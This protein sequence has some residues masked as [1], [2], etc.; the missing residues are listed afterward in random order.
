M[1]KFSLFGWLFIILNL[2]FF[3]SSVSAHTAHEHEEEEKSEKGPHGGRLL[4]DGHFSL[5][6]TIFE[7]GV[8]PEFRLF[9][10]NDN[11]PIHPSEVTAHITLYRLGSPPE[12]ITFTPIDSFLKSNQIIHEPHSF[13]VTVDA[14][15]QEK[16]HQWQFSTYEG[17]TQ[18]A[19]ETADATGI[20]TETAGPQTI[21]EEVH[22]NGFI[23]LNPNTT[24]QVRARFPGIVKEVKKNIGEEVHV[25]D[26]LA[27]VESNESLQPYPITAPLNGTILRRDTNIGD[28][29]R[30]ASLFTIASLD[31]VW[32]ELYV[33]PQDYNKIK[34]GQPLLIHTSTSDDTTD[35]IIS[36]V[37]PV[38]DLSSQTYTIRA[39]LENA[40]RKWLPGMALQGTAIIEKHAVPL[41]V[42]N[43]AIQRFRDFNVV[44]Q[45]VGDFY[46]VRMLELGKKDHTWTEVLSGLSPGASYV[47]ENSFLIKADIE[48]SGAVHDH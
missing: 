28:V 36:F 1:N 21:L 20:E 40:N 10:Y 18:I 29:A 15:Y 45:Q 4:R 19:K 9:P 5:E 26:V 39:V 3:D 12:E 24:A 42:K 31:N 6:L 33:F 14:Q 13:D 38:A 23:V 46:E 7:K 37:T 34:V 22:L 17:R 8:P 2:L 41:A 16:S 48:K 35:S 44:F 27:V 32:A 25:G 30:D 11:K 47:V 43:S